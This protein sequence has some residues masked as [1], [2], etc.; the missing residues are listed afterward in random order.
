MSS[1]SNAS[2]PSRIAGLRDRFHR[3]DVAVFQNLAQRNWPAAG[4]VLPRLSR[5]ANHGLLWFGAAAGMAAFGGSARARRAALRGIASLA[6]ASATINTVAKGAV[7][8][9]R[10]I[11]DAV[12][13]IRQLKRQPVTTS[14]P[15]GHA[16]SAAAFATGVAL[17]SRG[18]GAVVAPVALSVAASRVYTGV[19][20]PSDVLAGA[21]LGVGAAFALRGVIPTRGQL[22]APGRPPADAPALPEGRG[23]VVVANQESGT[24]TATAALIRN[25]LPEAE[26]VECAP[27]RLASELAQ[28]AE[29]CTALGVCGG[30][31]TV[32][33]AA[34]VAVEHEVPLAVFPGGTLNHFAYDLGIETVADACSALT[35]GTAVRTDVGR[36]RPGPEGADGYFLNAFSLGVYP[37]LVRMRERWSPR[38]GG[39][40]AGVLAALHVLRGE[41]PLEAELQGR[42]RPLWLLFVGNGLFQRVGPAPGRRHNLADG[43][44]DVRVVHGGRTPGLRLL[45]AAVAGPL[46]RSPMHAAVRRQRVRISGLKPGTPYAYDGEVT[47]SESELLIDKL[48]EAL[49]V[50]CPR[51]R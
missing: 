11:L 25:A 26:I 16:A 19:H 4:P 24:A 15:S 13:V 1:A 18:W 37:E 20:Y 51:P 3:R 30:D 35:T 14:F 32:N 21:A 9:Q 41:R 6:V 12:P 8:R 7:R 45:A 31:G 34:S 49:T 47:H 27:G 28:A 22:P 48:P 2:V 17:E 44:L 36:F 10:P 50:Y 5:S 39:W 38:I 40:P 46:T 33:L 42:C 43:L 23:L 29:R